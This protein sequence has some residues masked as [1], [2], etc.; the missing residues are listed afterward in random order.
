MPKSRNRS[1]RKR[2]RVVNIYKT[3]ETKVGPVRKWVG[4]KTINKL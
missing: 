4:K 2:R 3:V 1:A